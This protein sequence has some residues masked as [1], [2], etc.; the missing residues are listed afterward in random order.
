[1]ANQFEAM[2][3]SY[4]AGHSDILHED[5]RRCL[6]N[7]LS[8]AFWKGYDLL[9]PYLVDQGTWA[10]A[11]YRA[12]QTQRLLD[13]DTKKKTRIAAVAVNEFGDM[14]P[15]TMHDAK[16][17]VEEF[18]TNQYGKVWAQMKETGARVAQCEI[19]LLD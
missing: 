16:E 13:D 11:C 4:S 3:A 6:G 10:W 2:L 7:T 8:C 5:G 17:Q 9:P 1:M 14:L 18:M 19:K 12:G 15:R